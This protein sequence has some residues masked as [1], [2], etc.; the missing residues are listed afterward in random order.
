[1]TCFM[2][3]LIIDK[4]H[5]ILGLPAGSAGPRQSCLLTEMKCPEELIREKALRD[6][7][8]LHQ[9]YPQLCEICSTMEEAENGA[10]KSDESKI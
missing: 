1:M 4:S 10:R 8:V 6:S 7:A 2:L 9:L 3:T 5:K